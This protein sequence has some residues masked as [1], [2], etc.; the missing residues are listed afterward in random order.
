MNKR[1]KA[2]FLDR[3]GVLIHEVHY[4]SRLDQ[5]K[6]FDDVPDGLIQLKSAGFKLIL[7]TNQSGVARGY[8]DEK[9][10]HQANDYL[11]NL[12]ITLKSGLDAIYY[13]PHH[14]EG[15]PPYNIACDCRK[16][17]AGMIQKAVKEHN[18]DSQQSFVIGDK[19]SDIELAINSDT[20]GILLKTGHGKK[21]SDILAK[22]YPKVHAFDMFSEAV[23]YIL[24]Q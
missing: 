23:D 5:I 19:V 14:P 2:V 18:I 21:Q 8:F 20:Q 6:L 24:S 16:P 9:F 4:L 17:A 13:C 1:Q 10:V 12:L 7:V 15:K 3:D 11:N 22:K